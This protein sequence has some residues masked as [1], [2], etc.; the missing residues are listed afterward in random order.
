MLYDPKVMALSTLGN[1]EE[2]KALGANATPPMVKVLTEEEPVLTMEPT[3]NEAKVPAAFGAEK[4]A[5][6]KVKVAVVM[7][8]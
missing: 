6:V 5:P 1:K 3:F 4:M 8:F 7:E 2:V